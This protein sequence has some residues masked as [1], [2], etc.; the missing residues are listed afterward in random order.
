MLSA[1]LEAGAALLIAIG[2][3]LFCAG[4]IHQ[5]SKHN[6]ED[7]EAIREALVNGHEDMMATIKSYQ[8][9]MTDLLSKNIED[10]KEMLDKE[11]DNSRDSLNREISHLKDLISLTNNETRED[12]KR[13]QNE[14][15]ESNNLKAKILLMQ[16]SL[17]A[18]HH[19]LDIEPPVVIEDE[20]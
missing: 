16:S 9:S 17:K 7:I 3:F 8:E 12:I 11:K 20:D 14:Q 6:R 5:S 15:R 2:G 18:L 10:M 1:G 19:R 4:Q 13:L